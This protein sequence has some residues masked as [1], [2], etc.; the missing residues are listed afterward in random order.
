MAVKKGELYS[1]EPDR[2]DGASTS[3]AVLLGDIDMELPDEDLPAYEDNPSQASVAAPVRNGDPYTPWYHSP[4]DLPFSSR[5]SAYKEFRTIF[6]NYSQQPGA[7]ESM[8]RAQAECPPVYFVQL[9][10]NH[11]ETRRNGNKETKETITDFHLLINITHLLALGPD[12]G[13]EIELLAD[14]QRGFRGTRFPSFSPN[15]SDV[16][17]ADALRAWCD[18]YV[19][20]SSMV[21]CFTL[22]REIRNHDTW[23]LEQLLR[24]AIQSTGYR[25][26]L[27][28]EFPIQYQS[29][30]VYS[31][32]LINQWRTTTWIRWVFY[33]S[34]LW[35]LT[36]PFLILTTS[37]YSVIKAIYN[38]AD[39]PP[40]REET[41]RRATVMGEV[42]WFARWESAIKRA[43]LARMQNR[44]GSTLTEEY[45]LATSRADDRGIVHEEPRAGPLPSTGNALADG[46]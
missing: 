4:P 6:P 14:N 33:L 40:S 36:W 9:H 34:F 17:E 21:K 8:I 32:G 29:V 7:L 5:D 20:D 35:I 22:E 27:K 16:E 38:Y 23:K 25:G 11:T 1:D 13:G 39:M 37:R 3:S 46:A 30:V 45:R 12:T 41:A 43:A 10:G 42:A 19:A 28:V 24:S 31:P 26:H 2:D 15:V 44:D 18:R